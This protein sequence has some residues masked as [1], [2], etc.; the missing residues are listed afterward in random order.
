MMMLSHNSPLSGPRSARI[1]IA[2]DHLDSQDALRILLEAASY[3]VLVASDGRAAI[4]TALEEVPDLILMDIMMPE[5]DGIEVT[6]RLRRNQATMSIPIIAVTAMEGGQRLALEA[7]ADDFMPK[8]ID[9]RMLLRKIN[10]FLEPE[11]E[12][13]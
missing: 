2:E 1:L 13:L 10:G 11:G 12:S 5:L 9:A 4:D 7:G 8:P 6:R 3:Q